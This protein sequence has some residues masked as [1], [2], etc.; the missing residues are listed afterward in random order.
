LVRDC[1]RC[2][3]A[4]AARFAAGRSADDNAGNA[5]AIDGAAG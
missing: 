3:S 5:G 4:T 1:R 2:G